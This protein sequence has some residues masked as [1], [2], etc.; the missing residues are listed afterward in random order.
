MPAIPPNRDICLGRI[1]CAT[2]TVW[3]SA[4]TDVM[5]AAAPLGPRASGSHAGNVE[6]AVHCGRW[7][8]LLR[9]S[10]RYTHH[11]RRTWRFC[12]PTALPSRGVF[13]PS[14][15][16]GCSRPRIRFPRSSF[17]R[18]SR[19]ASWCRCPVGTTQSASIR[20]TYPLRSR[21]SAYP[22][23]DELKRRPYDRQRHALQRSS[24]EEVLYVR[25]RRVPVKWTVS[26]TFQR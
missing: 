13:P 24:R 26:S 22:K 12:P 6:G 15:D 21:R 9:G 4:V 20:S 7:N 25:R 16:S 10:S 19:T 1:A 5:C 2:S 8:G 11:I 18:P 17:L 14:R 3:R 23:W